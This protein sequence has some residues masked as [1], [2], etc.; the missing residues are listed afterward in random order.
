[1]LKSHKNRKEHRLT[2]NKKYTAYNVFLKGNPT[3]I[4]TYIKQKD[5]FCFFHHCK[6]SYL[7]VKQYFFI[8]ILN[9]S[10]YTI[11]KTRKPYKNIL[12]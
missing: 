6:Y 10:I 3:N 2:N 1:M 5:S 9:H 8:S 7:N 4:T 11:K 12:L